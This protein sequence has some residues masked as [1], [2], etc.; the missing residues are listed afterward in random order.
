[1]LLLVIRPL[2]F[3][4][5]RG[6]FIDKLALLVV[7]GAGLAQFLAAE[8]CRLPLVALDTPLS[9]AVAGSL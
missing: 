8:T 7:A 1:M 3:L 6:T 5:Q 9:A 2:V 4:P